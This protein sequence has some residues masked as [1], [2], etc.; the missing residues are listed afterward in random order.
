MVNHIPVNCNKYQT[1]DEACPIIQ[2][3]PAIYPEGEVGP[4]ID[5]YPIEHCLKCGHSL[6]KTDEPICLHCHGPLSKQGSFR[7]GAPP[8]GSYHVYS[9]KCDQCGLNYFS[10]NELF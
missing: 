3:Y 10:H 7:E 2:T 8:K 5:E 6:I 1:R 4:G 9:F